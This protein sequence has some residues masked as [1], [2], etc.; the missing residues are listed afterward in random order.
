M[1]ISILAAH[2][3]IKTS[4]NAKELFNSISFINWICVCILFRLLEKMSIKVGSV[5]VGKQPSMYQ[6]KKLGTR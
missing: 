6:Q 4:R 5:K 1:L 2:F 3:L